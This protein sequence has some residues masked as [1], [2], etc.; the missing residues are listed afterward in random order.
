MKCED[1]KW[2]DD[3]EFGENDGRC[4]LYSPKLV[5]SEVCQEETQR[6]ANMLV[7]D[8]VANAIWPITFAGDWCGE[9]KPKSPPFS[10]EDL[11]FSVRTR[12]VLK[13]MNIQ[14]EADF[15]GLSALDISRQ[16][17]AGKATLRE[18]QR[19]QNDYNRP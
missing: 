12:G 2:W 14:T 18:I 9:F 3:M 6:Y 13:K 5:E 7:N 19:K 11:C 1:C 4:R 10:I 16:K 15:L 17:Y 8:W